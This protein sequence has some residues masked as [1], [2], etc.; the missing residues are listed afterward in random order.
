MKSYDDAIDLAGAQNR[1]REAT[2]GKACALFALERLD[3]AA[4]LFETIAGTKEWRGEAT[5][6]SLHHLGLIAA[7]RG[8]QPKAIAFF[9]RVFVSQGRHTDWVAKS[10]LESGRAFEALGKNTEAV[11]TYREMLRNERLRER[12][13]IALATQRLAVL[14]PQ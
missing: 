11:A 8:D 14:A 12:P 10:Y 9:Q 2:V 1:L 3:D 6:L 7:R 5:A 13:E 4:K